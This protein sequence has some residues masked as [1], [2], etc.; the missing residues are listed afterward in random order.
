MMYARS[1]AMIPKNMVVMGNFCFCVAET[2]KI[3]FSESTDP[4]DLLHSIND[5]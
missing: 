1:S 5:V 4:S 2:L 3:I